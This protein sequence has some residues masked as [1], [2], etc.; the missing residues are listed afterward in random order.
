MAQSIEEYEAAKDE[1]KRA[2]MANLV[3]N[4]Q[5]LGL[6]LPASLVREHGGTP[7]PSEEQQSKAAQAVLAGANDGESSEPTADEPSETAEPS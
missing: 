7:T 2:R 6:E 4:R 1:E 3:A 5:K